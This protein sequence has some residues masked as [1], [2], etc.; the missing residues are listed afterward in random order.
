M[1]EKKK[2]ILHPSET[3][4]TWGAQV[5]VTPRESYRKNLGSCFHAHEGYEDDWEQVAFIKAT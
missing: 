1:T 2:Q 4:K 5:G 3:T